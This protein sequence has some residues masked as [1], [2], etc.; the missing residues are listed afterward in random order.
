VPNRIGGGDVTTSEPAGEKSANGLVKSA[1]R[2]LLL[3]EYLSQTGQASFARIVRD[4][5]LPTSSTYQLLQ[6]AMTRGFI[7]MDE[8]TRHFRLGFRVWEVAQSL[9]MAGDLVALAQPLMDELV[10]TTTETVQLAKLDGLENVYLAI[11]ESPHPMKLVSSVG[12][13][14]PA[15]TTGVGKALLASLPEAALNSLLDG[16]DLESFTP[17]TI[18]DHAALRRELQRIRSQGYAEDREEYI[19]GCRCVAIPILDATGTTLAAMSVSIPTPRYNRTIAR[20]A[21]ESLAATV[22]RLERRARGLSAN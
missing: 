5:N 10:R 19:V 2:V 7:E 8:T 20:R 1:D 3:L 22:T 4:L 16:K 17:R 13:R 12:A 9:A 11:S 6:T 18:T 21:R 15:H 14:L